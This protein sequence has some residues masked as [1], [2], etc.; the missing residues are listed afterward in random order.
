VYWHFVCYDMD[1]FAGCEIICLWWHLSRIL[2]IGS[3]F[4]F[5]PCLTVWACKLNMVFAF[6]GCNVV[7]IVIAAF[8]DSVLVPSSRVRQTWRWLVVSGWRACLSHLK[9]SSSLTFQDSQ[10]FWSSSVRHACTLPI[11][12]IGCHEMSVA[13]PPVNTA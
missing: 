8:Q 9:G 11:Q 12:P 7:V 10:F 6:L 13:K 5:L 4:L 2:S 1:R 3:E